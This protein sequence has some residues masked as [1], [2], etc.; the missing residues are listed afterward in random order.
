MLLVF[1]RMCMWAFSV[2]V[3]FSFFECIW[4][5]ELLVV[6]CFVRF[7]FVLLSCPGNGVFLSFSFCSFWLN[8]TSDQSTHVGCL[9]RL[10][11]LP[12]VFAVL[13]SLLCAIY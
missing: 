6:V 2:F 5:S 11:L 4:L 12:W 7:F 9:A 10:C 8:P 13:Y 3:L 1:V